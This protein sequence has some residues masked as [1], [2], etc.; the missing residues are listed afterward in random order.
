MT[1]R[2]EPTLYCDQS[3]LRKTWQELLKDLRRK[4]SGE[5]ERNG[6]AVCEADDGISHELTVSAMFFAV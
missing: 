3:L 6:E 2:T 5:S 1:M 4:T